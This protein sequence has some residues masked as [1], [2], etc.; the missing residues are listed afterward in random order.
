MSN[1][2]K[3]KNSIFTD[4]SSKNPKEGMKIEDFSM[5][6]IDHILKDYQEI[7]PEKNVPNSKQDVPLS[8]E[9]NE[10]SKKETCN[11]TSTN[12]KDESSKSAKK[13][14]K[15][16]SKGK[17]IVSSM[18]AF[19]ITVVGAG[20]YYLSKKTMDGQLAIHLISP[21]VGSF[22]S[23]EYW[24]WSKQQAF[25]DAINVEQTAKEMKVELDKDETMAEALLDLEEYL[26]VTKQIMDLRDFETVIKT[27]EVKGMEIS[28]GVEYNLT[29]LIEAYNKHRNVDV[30]DYS[31]EALEKTEVINKIATIYRSCENYFK[32]GKAT[33]RLSSAIYLACSSF[34]GE[35]LGLTPEEKARHTVEVVEATEENKSDKTYMLYGKQKVQLAGTIIKQIDNIETLDAAISQGEDY[36]LTEQDLD[37]MYDALNTAKKIVFTQPG[38]SCYEAQIINGKKLVLLPNAATIAK[39]S[40][41]TLQ[42]KK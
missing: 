1:D 5:D 41:E 27:A 21:E 7:S 6:N 25:E 29:S 32:S 12:K 4:V 35:Q 39:K 19:A 10:G 20:S 14:K 40:I 42:P 36:T 18:V 30:T 23:A 3:N 22:Q 34:C 26:Y 33:D 17:K 28:S 8:I 16:G 37:T 11:I 2:S 24:Q 13:E 31:L 9:K 38:E 15:H